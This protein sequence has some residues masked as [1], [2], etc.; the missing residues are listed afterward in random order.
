[1]R[2]AAILRCGA[3]K[4][5]GKRCRTELG[6]VVIGDDRPA[7]AS[8]MSTTF[9]SV[10]IVPK[11]GITSI[12]DGFKSPCHGRRFYDRG[13]MKFNAQMAPGA[14]RPAPITLYCDGIEMWDDI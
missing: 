12:G 2:T 10:D 8:Y 3:S 1:M 6:K 7:P 9:P 5:K 11:D 14:S 13:A 4:G